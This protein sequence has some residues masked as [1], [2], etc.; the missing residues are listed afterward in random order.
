MCALQHLNVMK[1][2]HGGKS[3]ANLQA[4]WNSVLKSTHTP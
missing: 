1:K 3:K 4:R 2:E